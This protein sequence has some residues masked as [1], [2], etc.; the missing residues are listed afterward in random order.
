MEL[1]YCPSCKLCSHH[2]GLHPRLKP[3]AS[4]EDPTLRDEGPTVA[5]SWWLSGRT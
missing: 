4:A 2:G 3:S 1:S 5:S